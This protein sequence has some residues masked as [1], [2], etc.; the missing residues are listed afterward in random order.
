[1]TDSSHDSET[2]K[3]TAPSSHEMH[4]RVRPTH[5][6]PFL[7]RVLVLQRIVSTALSS[8]GRNLLLTFATIVV[9]SLM[10]GSVLLVA[11]ASSLGQHARQE[12][13]KRITLSLEVRDTANLEDVQ[14]LRQSLLSINRPHV[15]SVQYL[16]KEDT[17]R[18]LEASGVEVPSF[19][20]QDTFPARLRIQTDDLQTR[21]AIIAYVT[22]STY[23]D[24]VIIPERD[25]F[26]AS[27]EDKART[28]DSVISSAQRIGV[29]LATVFAIIAALVV[30]VTVRL[31]VYTRRDELAIMQ[32]VGASRTS[33]IGPFVLEGMLNGI[34]ASGIALALFGPLIQN[35]FPGLESFFEGFSVEQ[36][37]AADF[38]RLLLVLCGIGGGLG[39]I[40]S[41]AAT[42]WYLRRQPV[43]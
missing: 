16:S 2:P 27:F 29:T 5:T 39:A 19:V 34:L 11:A 41:L 21:G 38:P 15:L 13:S 33:I 3:K 12:I 22:S 10:L 24:T 1:M 36:I 43:M 17:R 9:V 20:T 23:K 8:M 28:I 32:L 35:T 42:A 6:R 4:A 40:A 7:G 14:S 37:I 26:N 31:A 18:E 30:S 25:R